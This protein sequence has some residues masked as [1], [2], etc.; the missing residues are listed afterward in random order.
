VQQGRREYF[1]TS[2][3]HQ[4]TLQQINK[5]FEERYNLQIA[6]NTHN[7]AHG[8]CADIE[9]VIKDLTAVEIKENGGCMVHK[10]EF[11][12]T[13]DGAPDNG[14][15]VKFMLVPLSYNT[16]ATQSRNS[17]ILIGNYKDLEQIEFYFGSQFEKIKDLLHHG[18]FIYNNK[19]RLDLKLIQVHDLSL[20][21]K[22]CDMLRDGMF[23]PFCKCLIEE[24]NDFE[25]N[26]DKRVLSFIWGFNTNVIYYTLHSCCRTIWS[27]KPRL[28]MKILRECFRK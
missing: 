9:Q 18:S 28:S 6:E 11:K 20:L 14:E 17:A 19:K 3:T 1:V 4:R 21:A 7:T 12:L 2:R 27:F 16:F 15:Y 8:R 10:L 24:R 13:I 23:C 22:I 5:E 25:K 26:C